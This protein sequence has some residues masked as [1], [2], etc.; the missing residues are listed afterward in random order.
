MEVKWGERDAR[1]IKYIIVLDMVEM[2]DM[3]RIIK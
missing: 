1:G 2:I 3:K